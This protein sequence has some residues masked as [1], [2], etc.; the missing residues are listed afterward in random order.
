[1][2]NLEA[3]RSKATSPSKVVAATVVVTKYL[4]WD[5]FSSISLPR[6]LSTS[7]LSSFLL[8]TLLLYRLS[9]LSAIIIISTILIIC[10]CVSHFLV[11]WVHSSRRLSLV[12][13]TRASRFVPLRVRRLGCT[14]PCVLLSP[15]LAFLSFLFHRSPPFFS[16]LSTLFPAMD[17]KKSRPS[18]HLINDRRSHREA[19]DSFFCQ[20]QCGSSKPPRARRSDVCPGD[21]SL[22][23]QNRR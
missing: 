17:P 14:L 8:F 12:S 20:W 7:H 4:V 19:H 22:Q 3:T 13:Y 11:Y 10:S 16:Y 5:L 1:M 9:Q 2:D 23:C 6:L 18:L 21:R 15:L